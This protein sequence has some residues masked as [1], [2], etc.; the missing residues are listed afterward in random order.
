MRCLLAWFFMFSCIGELL[1][2]LTDIYKLGQYVNQLFSEQFKIDEFTNLY[3]R[4]ID[5]SPFRLEKFD[6]AAE[7]RAYTE[8]IGQAVAAK[9]KSLH[10]VVGWVEEAVAKY[11]WNPKLQESFVQSLTLSSLKTSHPGMQ[12]KP[13]YAFKIWP[14]RSGVHIPVEVYVGDP[15]VFHT[16]H[17][18]QSLD[19]IFNNSTDLHFV[20]FASITGI[21]SVYPAFPWQHANVDM[22]DIRETRWYMQGASVPKAVLIMVD[23]SGSMTGQSL[24]VAN[25]SAQKLVKSLDENDYF[26]VGQFPAHNKQFA[27][28]NNSEPIC[29]QTFVRATKRNIQKLINNEIT[30][31]SAKGY[32][33]FSKAFEEAIQLFDDLKNESFPGNGNLPCSKII[34]MYTDSAF[35]FDSRTKTVLEEQLGDIKLLVYAFGEPVSDVPGYQREAAKFGGCY[36]DLPSVG[37]VSNMMKDYHDR[38]TKVACGPNG[39]PIQTEVILHGANEVFR[40]KEYQGNGLMVTVSMPVYNRSE[41][42]QFLGLMGTNLPMEMLTAAFPQYK[43]GPLGYIFALNSNGD[44]LFHPALR[45]RVPFTEEPPKFDWLNLE[46]NIEGKKTELR[47]KLIDQ[48]TGQVTITDFIRVADM[49]HTHKA[50]RSY[51]FGGIP[52]TEFGMAVV[53]PPDQHFYLE[54]ASPLLWSVE[55]DENGDFTVGDTKL[56]NLLNEACVFLPLELLDKDWKTEE[57]F[58]RYLDRIVKEAEA[59]SSSATTTESTEVPIVSTEAQNETNNETMLHK[60]ELFNDSNETS[61][62]LDFRKLFK[63]ALQDFFPSN[64]ETELDCISNNTLDDSE[65]CPVSTTPVSILTV[66]LAT[67]TVVSED[68][69]I[70]TP[71]A[72]PTESAMT[73]ESSSDLTANSSTPTPPP[74][75]VSVEEEMPDENNALRR[76]LRNVHTLNDTHPHQISQLLFDLTVAEAD[77]NQ[78]LASSSLPHETIQSRTIRLNSGLGW[79]IPKSSN[80]ALEN[81]LSK[82][83]ISPILQRVYDTNDLLFWI[84][85]KFGV[86]E[87]KFAEPENVTDGNMTNPDM[88]YGDSGS[89]LFSSDE[90]G[91]EVTE[92]DNSNRTE[93]PS[94]PVAVTVFKALELPGKTT[95][96]KAGVMGLTLDPTFLPHHL[97]QLTLCSE[98]KVCYL[99]DDAGYI[100]A[101]NNES[102]NYQVTHFLGAADPP[103]M[104]SLLESKI[105]ET[106]IDY[107]FQGL[108]DSEGLEEA[109]KS[110]GF[111][112]K[113]FLIPGRKHAV[114]FALLSYWWITDDR[115][116]FHWPNALAI[117]LLLPIGQA[118]AADI[119]PSNC[120]QKLHRYFLP[121]YSSSGNDSDSLFSQPITTS[122]KI[123]CSIDCMREW[124]AMDIEGTNL[125]L[126][127]ASPVCAGNCGPQ[128]EK[129]PSDPTT[130]DGPDVCQEVR[131]PRYRKPTG[132]CPMT[133]FLYTDLKCSSCNFQYSVIMLLLP[134]LGLLFSHD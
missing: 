103:L 1:G 30:N 100:V 68:T 75:E 17:W 32:A 48:E 78:F 47:R 58:R 109:P 131:S 92:P 22:F 60:T 125:K 19:D 25:I 56:S 73:P 81:E 10:E 128:D 80:E 102:L 86:P 108:C 82:L 76:F 104:R 95:P 114:T 13:G 12:S 120:L 14:R 117:G 55:E 83:P 49:V 42:L 87:R 28:V 123:N 31:I 20:Y 121:R 118:S 27:L 99:L 7:I 65:N 44:V 41:K 72:I 63:R 98:G 126:I 3:Q 90:E 88:D 50:P 37:A 16:L 36:E 6:A 35:E 105:Y 43:L 61:T 21:F 91:T 45:L 66:S 89:N 106:V 69:L 79:T 9:N 39:R 107:N 129:V 84:P 133:E 23:T 96:F 122:G 11:A 115:T 15:N 77:V 5:R 4:E 53:T 113:A 97:Q 59:V 29:F 101:V 40:N 134:L 67:E 33:N 119:K 57:H 64:S 24:K 52:R 18:M 26:A 71:T 46:L 93:I 116:I 127:I 70:A 132:P 34:I 85:V 38:S 110:E 111:R 94:E 51:T 112:T 62:Q 2:Q 8:K 130:S 54:L 74:T 124:S